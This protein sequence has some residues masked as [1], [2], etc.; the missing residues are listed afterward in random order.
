MQ[1][2]LRHR[3]PLL[4]LVIPLIAGLALARATGAGGGLSWLLAPALFLALVSLLLRESH[5]RLWAVLFLGAVFF[6]GLALW[7]LR[8]PAPFERE[9]L[10]PREVRLALRCEHVYASRDPSLCSGLG[11]IVWTPS[12][13]ETLNGHRVH[14]SLGAEA[15]PETLLP[16][17]V[18]DVLALLQNVPSDPAP[19]S[20]DAYLDCA[21]IRL[22]LARGRIVRL[23]RPGGPWSRWKARVLE[24]LE[25]LLYHSIQTKRPGQAASYRAMMLGRAGDLDQDQKAAFRQSGTM[26]LF[27]ISGLHIGVIALALRGLLALFR[28]PARLCFLPETF[29]LWLFV[30]VTG[31]SPSAVRAFLMVA[32]FGL[33]CALRQPSSALSCLLA[34][35][36]VALI[37]DPAQLFG[38]SFQLSYGI[39]AALVLYAAPL[40]ERVLSFW[41]PYQL[42]PK[43]TWSWRHHLLDKTWR[44][45]VASLAAGGA[46]TLVGLPAGLHFFGMLTPGGLLVN[47]ALIPV[48]GLVI[49]SGLGSLGLGFLLGETWTS[50]SNHAAALVLLWME[51]YVGLCL[52]LPGVFFEGEFRQTWLGSVSTAGILL[53]L[54]W[55]YARRWRPSLL[56]FSLPCIFLLLLLV[57]GVQYAS[58]P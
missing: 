54:L 33:S 51:A 52:R 42:L 3:A 36:F 47:L 41:G 12:H 35:A 49:Y 18:L 23:L 34:S 8:V 5:P 44:W 55:G 6:T 16:G 14:F 58:S 27:S 19:H 32:L 37:L 7:P 43:I 22:R 24:S 21:G 56:L 17:A 39:V 30:E 1:R 11:V 31:S 26:H 48:S 40:S 10:P 9:G 57:A 38:A 15:L 46:A 4:W 2:S 50:L 53:M 13:L 20:F 28:V 45:L 29:A 25:T